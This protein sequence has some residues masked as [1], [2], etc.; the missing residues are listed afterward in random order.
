MDNPINDGGPAF[1]NPALANES[2][3]FSSDVTGMT[4]RDW[5]AGQQQ[6]TDEELG[7]AKAATIMGSKPPAW[8]PD[9]ATACIEWWSAAEARLKY[10]K[11]DA[12][13]AARAKSGVV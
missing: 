3:S 6:I 12:M 1:P 4:L 9:T 7:E 13:I 2:C 10:I 11:A 5:F 8:G